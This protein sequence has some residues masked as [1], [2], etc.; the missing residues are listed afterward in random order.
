MR[1]LDSDMVDAI[2]FDL[3]IIPSNKSSPKTKTKS[4]MD[5]NTD[6]NNEGLIINKDNN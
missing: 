3:T 6:L 5:N 1:N 2:D 4:Y